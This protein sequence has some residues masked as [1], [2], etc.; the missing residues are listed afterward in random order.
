MTTEQYFKDKINWKI[1]N[2]ILDAST[3]LDDKDVH[4]IV[5]IEVCEYSFNQE[6]FHE[7]YSEHNGYNTS[8]AAGGYFEDYIENYE[9]NGLVYTLL[10]DHEY[11]E[12]QSVIN[13][14]LKR[15]EIRFLHDTLNVFRF[16][17]KA[18]KK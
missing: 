18:K 9:D 8:I 3:E 11:H 13:K 7:I 12:Y 17:E 14:I 4:H 1:Y 16:T 2:I 6:I 15:K 5:S 10:I